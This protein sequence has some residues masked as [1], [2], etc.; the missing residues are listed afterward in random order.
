MGNYV[1]SVPLIGL[2]FSRGYCPPKGYRS[3]QPAL[4]RAVWV[5]DSWLMM[6]LLREGED[7]NQYDSTGCTALHVAAEMGDVQCLLVSELDTQFN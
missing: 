3:D 4:L 1:S 6:H 2:R 5:S 7:I